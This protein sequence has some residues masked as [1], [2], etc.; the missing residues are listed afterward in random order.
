[1]DKSNLVS[2]LEKYHLNGNVDAV[3]WVIKDKKLNIRFLSN[4]KNLVGYL[5]AND[6]D[7][8]DCELGIYNT[9]QFIKLIKITD[10]F[11]EL[12]IA[13]GNYGIATELNISDNAYDLKYYLSDLQMI[14]EPDMV[15]EPISYDCTIHITQDLIEKFLKAKKALGDVRQFTVNTDV[16]DDGSKVIFTIGEGNNYSNKIKFKEVAESMFG[17][18]T[19]P[20][21]V[22]LFAAIM[23]ANEGFTSGKIEIYNEGLM[24]ITFEEGSIKST[25]FLVRLQ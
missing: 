5:E 15:N 25:Y 1:M 6:F 18:D 12:N 4:N 24:K 22:D 2:V 14:E 11:I 9:T 13:K 23:E 20:F 19:M 8:D 3:K 16:D 10:D 21:P 7:V 17:I